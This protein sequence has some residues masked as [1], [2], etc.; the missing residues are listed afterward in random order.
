LTTTRTASLSRLTLLRSIFLLSALAVTLATQMVAQQN[1]TPTVTAIKAEIERQKQSLKDKPV[2]I[3]DFG[4]IGSNIGAMLKSAEDTLN[5]GRTYSSM[6]SLGRAMDLLSG[7]RMVEA[8]AEV[9]KSGLP[10]FETEWGKASVELTS[11]DD[12]ARKRD[13]SKS[14]AAVQALAEAAQGK[15]IP[16]LEGGR[17][18]ASATKPSDGLFYMGQAQGEAEFSSFLFGLR[19]PRTAAGLPLRSYVPELQRLQEKTNAAFQPPKSIDLHDRFIALNSTI[20]LADELDASKSYAGALYEYLEAT[21]H[22]GM[23]DLTVP[24]AAKVARLKTTLAEKEKELAASKRDDSIA[25]IFVERAQLWLAHPDGTPTAPD[26]FRAVRVV[27]EQVLPAY[28]AA[29]KPAVPVQR[30][31]VKTVDVTLVRWPYT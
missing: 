29:L 31:A 6:E 4:D 28:Y 7:A 18:F 20:K 12:N 2:N 1:P 22:Y 16:L 21:R 5:L 25:Q 19:L 3:P 15:A 17:G 30:A 8:K 26:E 13:W 9:V 24:D 23:L 27:V 11:L 10:A 14:K